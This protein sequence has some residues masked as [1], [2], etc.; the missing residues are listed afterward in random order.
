MTEF[1]HIPVK[2]FFSRYKYSS[3]V[4]LPIDDGRRPFN[5]LLV[6][7]N[8]AKEEMLKRDNGIS[9]VEN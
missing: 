6:K 9:P 5:L 1:E 3:D 2:K 4:Q 7:D 8:K